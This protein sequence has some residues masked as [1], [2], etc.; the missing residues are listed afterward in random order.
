[1]VMWTAIFSNRGRKYNFL[2][3]LNDKSSSGQCSNPPG[4]SGG[5]ASWEH[6][7]TK[8]KISIRHIT[9]YYAT[10]HNITCKCSAI[11]V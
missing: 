11:L 8:Y 5:T 6:T 9:N 10:K 1:M 4:Y 7:S 2:A 3:P